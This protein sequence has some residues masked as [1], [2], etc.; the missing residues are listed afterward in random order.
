MHTDPAAVTKKQLDI[1][2]QD[3]YLVAI[4]K[5]AGLLVHRSWLAAEAREF[6]MQMLRD[7]IGQH[8]YPVHRLDRPTS[9]ILLFALDPDTARAMSERFA[10]REVR[11]MYHAVV[12]G[13]VTEHGQIDYPLKEELDKVADKQAQRDKP[14]QSAVTDFMC[15]RQV[16]LPYQVSTRHATSRYS[17]VQLSPKTGR[18]HQLRRHLA[19][20][21]HPIIGDTS[22]GDGRHNAFFRSHFDSHRLLLCATGLEFNHPVTGKEV[23]LRLPV[24]E[25]FLRA[26]K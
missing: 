19:H 16:E 12:R 23:N 26:F 2:Y 9:G 5:P 15:L 1:I 13:Y 4:D 18:K 17:L 6:A 11:K 21:R 25:L 24:P 3:E 14:A 7:Q 10:S 20:I 22:H 8:V